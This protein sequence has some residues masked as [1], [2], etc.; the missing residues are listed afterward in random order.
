MGN[1]SPSFTISLPKLYKNS[2]LFTYFGTY[3]ADL[4]LKT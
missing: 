3:F 4:S 2:Q 1:S